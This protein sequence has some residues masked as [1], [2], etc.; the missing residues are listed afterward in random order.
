MSKIN[1]L[2]PLDLTSIPQSTIF[3]ASTT[4]LAA[5][6]VNSYNNDISIRDGFE[7]AAN[8]HLRIG[9]L[10]LTKEEYETC[11]TYLLELTKKAKPE[12]FI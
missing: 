7:L 11:M 8:S 9:N 6:A 3:A 4:T 5:H 2:P 1:L 12:E 10:T